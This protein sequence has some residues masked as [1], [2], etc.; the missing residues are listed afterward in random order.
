MARRKKPGTIVRIELDDG[1]HTY[2]RE[3]EHPF[4]AV[5]DARTSEPLQPEQIIEHPALFIVGVFDKAFNRWKKI[6]YV[7]L[8][9]N[10]LAVPDR[11]IQD[12]AN[13]A[14]CRLVDINGNARPATIEECEGRESATIWDSDEVADRIRDHYAGR[15][16]RLA[17]LL[18]VKR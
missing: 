13:P 18:K 4:V 14:N 12:V 1:H 11:F 15:P 8:R 7:P 17:E 3:L 2:A 16:N 10:E 9:P 5:Y 6:G